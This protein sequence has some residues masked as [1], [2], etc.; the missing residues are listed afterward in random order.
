MAGYFRC[1][2]NN[3]VIFFVQS[4]KHRKDKYEGRQVAIANSIRMR[5]SVEP[6]VSADC[7]E[8]N[9]N[10]YA[11]ESRALDFSGSGVDDIR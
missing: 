10:N 5:D 4:L 1:R 2:R 6:A 7:L 9:R 3:G 11:A 8:K